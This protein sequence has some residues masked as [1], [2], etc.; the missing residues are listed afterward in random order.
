MSAKPADLNDI[1]V[2]PEQKD[3]APVEQEV[4]SAEKRTK[5]KAKTQLVSSS[6]S[7]AAEDVSNELAS[8]PA[9]PRA[10][11]VEQRKI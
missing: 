4:T 8:S 7:Y 3:D 10:P 6:R 11:T 2:S 5:S 1:Q 9:P